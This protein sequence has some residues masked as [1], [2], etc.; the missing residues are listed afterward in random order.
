[1]RALGSAQTR[2]LLRVKKGPVQVCCSSLT[3]MILSELEFF[4]D[5]QRSGFR[6]TK[7]V[8]VRTLPY[9]FLAES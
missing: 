3:E 4:C 1:M 9:S 7:P 5:H 8:G 6:I 2:I